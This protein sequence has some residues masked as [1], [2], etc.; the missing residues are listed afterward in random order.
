MD[1]MYRYILSTRY[2]II[3]SAVEEPG[4]FNL[5]VFLSLHCHTEKFRG[6]LDER[7]LLSRMHCS[8]IFG[9]WIERKMQKQKKR[10]KEE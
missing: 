8:Q 4:I 5:F 3:L 2:V 10:R 7:F 9:I 6:R 1:D